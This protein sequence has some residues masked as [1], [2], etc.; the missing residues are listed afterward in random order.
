MKVLPREFY[1]RNTVTVAKELL[2]KNLVHKNGNKIIS[3][4]I[5]ETD[6]K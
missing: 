3:G 6:C 4:T 5:I 1:A 2:G